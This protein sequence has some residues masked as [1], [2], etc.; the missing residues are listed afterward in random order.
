MYEL[1]VHIETRSNQVDLISIFPIDVSANTSILRNE[2]KWT[3]DIFKINRLHLAFERNCQTCFNR[4][5]VSRRKKNK[6]EMEKDQIGR[7][8]IIKDKTIAQR[9]SSVEVLSAILKVGPR[10]AFQSGAILVRGYLT[11]CEN[12]STYAR[13]L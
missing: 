13:R 4:P 10:V 8:T 3:Y 5:L 12:P 1:F 11:V 9:E 6:Y 7:V 2:E